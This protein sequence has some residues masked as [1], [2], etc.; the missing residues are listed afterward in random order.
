MPIIAFDPDATIPLLLTGGT[1]TVDRA[2]INAQ[3]GNQRLAAERIA[4]LFNTRLV[5]RRAALAET[6]SSPIT[7]A[8]LREQSLLIGRKDRLA[9]SIGVLSK[10]ITQIGFLEGHITFLRE[11]IEELEAGNITAASFSAVFD[12]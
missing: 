4:D 8:L 12:N 7:D 9:E 10:S 1:G 5:A 2:L 11:Q 3:S 6:T